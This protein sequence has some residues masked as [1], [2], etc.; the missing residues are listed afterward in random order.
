VES[1][2]DNLILHVHIRC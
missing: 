1:S 2:T